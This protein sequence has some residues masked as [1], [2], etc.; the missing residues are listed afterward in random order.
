MGQPSL[1]VAR[2]SG[3]RGEPDEV[4]NSAPAPIALEVLETY[5]RRAP[6]GRRTDDPTRRS[7]ERSAREVTGRL[8]AQGC[9][10]GPSP[11]R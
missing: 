7:R 10:C 3:R 9:S 8:A 5:R 4:C 11:E 6:R 1:I 2:V